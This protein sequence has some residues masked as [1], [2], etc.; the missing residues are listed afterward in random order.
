MQEG[1]L[2]QSHL[3]EFRTDVILVQLAVTSIRVGCTIRPDLILQP[4]RNKRIKSASV[5][6]STVCAVFY[7]MH[8]TIVLGDDRALFHPCE[9]GDL[10][11]PIGRAVGDL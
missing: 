2:I 8:A 3:A 4:L 10:S 1:D 11:S 5:L 9:R 7:R 6:P